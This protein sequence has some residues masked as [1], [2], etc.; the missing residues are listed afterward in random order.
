MSQ[1][2]CAFCG[3]YHGLDADCKI[4][5]KALRQDAQKLEALTG[6]IHDG[7][8]FPEHQTDH[9]CEH[10]VFT[11][12]E[13]CNQCDPWPK[14][15]HAVTLGRRGGKVKSEAKAAAARENGKKGG[16]PKQARNIS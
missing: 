10:G 11:A 6:R 12:H 4:M 1:N 15:R 16:R 2:V 8:I 13:H 14:N 3:R 9:A 7:R 5:T